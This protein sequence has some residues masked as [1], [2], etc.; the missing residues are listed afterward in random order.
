ML[1]DAGFFGRVGCIVEYDILS[2]LTLSIS[3]SACQSRQVSLYIV[4]IVCLFGFFRPTREFFTHME[5]SLLS[6]LKDCKFWPVLDTH[7]HWYVNR[8]GSLTCHTYYDTGHPFIMVISEDPWHSR[9][10][11]SEWSCH[12]LFLRLSSVAAGIRTPNLPLARRTL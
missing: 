6:P 9:L 12:Y 5:T 10:L 8:K 2:I 1:S 11:P 7:G 3:R 4:L